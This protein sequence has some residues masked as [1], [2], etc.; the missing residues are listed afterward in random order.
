MAEQSG[1]KRSGKSGPLGGRY[2]RW[3]MGERMAGIADVARPSD[4]AVERLVRWLMIMATTLANLAGVAIVVGMAIWVVPLD[5]PATGD[6]ILVN[7][8]LTAV[9]LIVMVPACIIAITRGLRPGRNWLKE[10]RPPTPD[11]QRN[12]LR[13]PLYIFGGVGLVWLFAATGFGLLNGIAYSFETGFRLGTTIALAGLAT[14]AIAYLLSERLLR[15]AAARALGARGLERPVLPGITARTLFAWGL[16]SAIP[17][18]GLF[19][20]GL[21]AITEGD[22]NRDQLGVAVLVLCGIALIVGFVTILMVARITAVPVI[23]LRRA[24]AEVEEG[25]LDTEVPVYDG[26]ELGMLQS[27]FNRMVVGL[28]DRERIRELF[29]HHVGREVAREALEG[30]VEL[31]GE[32]RTVSVLFVDV[33]GSTSIAV[34][35][36]PK[37]VVDLLNRFFGIVIDTVDENGGWV[38]KFEGDAALAIFG[39]PSHVPDAA[40]RALATARDLIGRLEGIEGLEAAIGVATGE[41]VAGNIG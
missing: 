15:P 34:E 5:R 6:P 29:G 8:L 3:V 13:A 17:M 35:R 18:L 38:N 28:Q 10:E 14:C 4:R 16:G 32:V 22:Y 24:I 36:T 25:R 1:E 20:I 2:S 40:A 12:L 33:I 39:A 9:F 7:L 41:A 21:S 27:G 23:S 19:L 31:G 37:E 30:D 11:E 26:T